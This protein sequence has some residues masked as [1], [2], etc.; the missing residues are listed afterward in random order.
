M[1]AEAEY[2]E[3]MVERYAPRWIRMRHR[4]GLIEHAAAATALA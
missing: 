4:C 3:L 1:T 2:E